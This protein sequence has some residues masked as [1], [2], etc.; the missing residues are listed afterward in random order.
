MCF[1][2]PWVSSS[3]FTYFTARCFQAP[4][5]SVFRSVFLF[6]CVH[7]DCPIAGITG[8]WFPQPRMF[9]SSLVDLFVLLYNFMQSITLSTDFS[10]T[11]DQFSLRSLGTLGISMV[12]I[13]SFSL[14]LLLYTQ[15]QIYTNT[16]RYELHG[17]IHFI[18]LT[19]LFPEPC[20]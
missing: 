14:F 13:H 17:N 3:Y 18:L 4:L 16:M 8:M 15:T 11:P 7:D 10:D 12:H 1:A 20:P 6:L 5:C 2:S 19:T 9:V